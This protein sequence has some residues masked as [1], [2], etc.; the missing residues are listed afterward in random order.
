MSWELLLKQ[1]L[2]STCAVYSRAS[3]SAHA[4]ASKGLSSRRTEQ[5]SYLEK[6]ICTLTG[7]RNPQTIEHWVV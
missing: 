7:K 6:E 5:C 1:R 4:E 2:G 3:Q